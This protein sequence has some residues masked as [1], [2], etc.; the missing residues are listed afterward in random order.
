MTRCMPTSEGETAYLRSLAVV[1]NKFNGS[2]GEKKEFSAAA[3]CDVGTNLFLQAQIRCEG[4]QSQRNLPRRDKELKNTL[5][6]S[7]QY[8][9]KAIDLDEAD[10][11]PWCGLGC[12]LCSTDPLLAQH[13][14]CRSLQLDKSSA[15][16]WANLGLLYA[17]FTRLD[18]SEETIDALTQVADTPIMWI[19]RALLLE[20][21]LGNDDSEMEDN[22]RRAADAY[23]AALQVARHPAA[24]LG[25]SCTSCRG[26]NLQSSHYFDSDDFG[27]ESQINLSLY[28]D[29]TSGSDIGANI[30]GGVM[31][32]NAG[33]QLLQNE[34]YKLGC[35][36]IRAGT[37]DIV[38]SCKR[39]EQKTKECSTTDTLDYQTQSPGIFIEYN[40]LIK[41]TPRAT[42]DIVKSASLSCAKIVPSTIQLAA[43]DRVRCNMTDYT[44]LSAA[45]QSIR[46]H[47]EVGE[48][49]LKLAKQLVKHLAKLQSPSKNSFRTA[50]AVVARAK[51]ML[52][53]EMTS[54]SIQA[55][56]VSDA[57]ALSCHLSDFTT[58]D[59]KLKRQLSAD[60]QR[61]LILDPDNT[62][63]RA[64]VESIGI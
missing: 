5:V 58:H 12:A 41:E 63:A 57:L 38:Q 17:E 20:K 56:K 11:R 23:R 28:L 53:T 43:K 45:R 60:L 35:D 16:A 7:M 54:K 36:I 10:P 21:T 61:A 31:M 6:Q 59:R 50:K 4:S 46:E 34:E 44:G 51:Y 40:S 25:L 18:S 24:L 2:D 39:E 33:D 9:L 29:V 62:L 3:L 15:H 1:E 42:M 52:S 19:G 14:F 22:L 30:L 8:F 47:P 64:K 13:A 26:H 32:I 49:W 48:N 27:K 55:T 37:D